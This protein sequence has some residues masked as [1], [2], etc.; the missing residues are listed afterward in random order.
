[1]LRTATE[2][3]ANLLNEGPQTN[4]LPPELLARIFDLAI[5][6][7]P[8]ERA[9]QIVPLSH[10]CRYWRTALLSYPRIWSTVYMK[11]GHPSMVSEW[12]TRSQKVP[13]TIV[14]E[15]RDSYIHPP[16]RYLASPTATLANNHPA[17]CSRHQAVL[18]LD[19][20]LPHRSRIYDLR[21][22][23]YSSDP[24]WEEYDED[25]ED[26]RD[27]EPQ[28]L[29]HH[30]FKET[31]PNLQLLDFRAAHVEQSRVM[32]PIPDIFAGDLPRLKKLKYLGV[33]PSVAGAAKNLV[34]CKIGS[35]SWSPGSTIVY[36]DQLRDFFN[37]NKTLE[38]LT[39]NHCFPAHGAP[40]VPRS[41]PMID[42]K[43]LKIHCSSGHHLEN[44]LNFIHAPQFRN[45][46]TVQFSLLH[47]GIHQAVSTDSSG[48]TF[49]FSYYN[50]HPSS[51]PLR[52]FGAVITTL[53]LSQGITLER[54]DNEPGVYDFFRSLDAVQALE[55]DG[56]VADSVQNVLSVPGV[57]PGLR[58]IRV[59][60]S[61][62]DCRRT[63]QLLA[64]ASK[65]RMEEGNPLA[66]IEPLLAE[67][68]D[69]LDPNLRVEWRGSYEAEDMENLLS[70]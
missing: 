22:L 20:L 40:W 18:S 59:A 5:G 47:Y 49:Q 31:L 15:F 27:G 14:A 25:D 57:F 39:I 13:L 3:V 26:Y 24:H 44:F 46:D 37:K 19:Q 7:G 17:V 52:H 10:V 70:K 42:L 63:L 35:L 65:R 55:F 30:F 45:L 29:H 62:G 53:R 48:H 60:V 4:R 58:V 2:R 8:E 64:I 23:L 36:S 34:S 21:I 6:H 11:P 43:F 41:I 51:H 32:I 1:M 61:W 38:S 9:N 50:Y 28:L 69:G 16:C 56:T 33:T 67:G 68:E 12:L 54:L 66:T